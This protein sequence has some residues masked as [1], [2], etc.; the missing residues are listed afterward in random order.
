MPCALR[1]R[2]NAFVRQT[3]MNG[4]PDERS[5]RCWAIQR[6]QTQCPFGARLLAYFGEVLLLPPVCGGGLMGGE[7]KI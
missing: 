6:M 2:D 4:L 7:P 3:S 5:S 1:R